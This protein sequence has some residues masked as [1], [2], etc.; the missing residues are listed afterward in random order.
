MPSKKKNK[1]NVLSLYG[2]PCALFAYDVSYVYGAADIIL[3]LNIKEE[4]DI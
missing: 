3:W 2:G 1:E 4:L